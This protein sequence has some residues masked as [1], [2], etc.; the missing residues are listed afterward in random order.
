MRSK[1]HMKA[2][3]DDVNGFKYIFENIIKLGLPHPWDGNQDIWPKEQFKEKL[4]EKMNTN[5][6]YN[7]LENVAT[8]EQ[9]IERIGHQFQIWI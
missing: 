4:M 1:M 7:P 3:E 8:E 6:E 9:V 2:L 5:P